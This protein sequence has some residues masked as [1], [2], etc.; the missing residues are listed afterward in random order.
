MTSNITTTKDHKSLCEGTMEDLAYGIMADVMDLYGEINR[1][2]DIP[3]ID[4]EE[5]AS[6]TKEISSKA[7][8]I[9]RMVHGNIEGND[10]AERRTVTKLSIVDPLVVE[11]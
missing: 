2:R 1:L 6:A 7:Q 9:I 4:T 8:Q 3:G 11:K 5:I 10:L